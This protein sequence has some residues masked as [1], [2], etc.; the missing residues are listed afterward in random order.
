MG[1]ISKPLKV[2]T[3]MIHDPNM[4]SRWWQLTFRKK[5][6]PYLGEDDAIWLISFRLVQ[7]STLVS[8]EFIFFYLSKWSFVSGGESFGYLRKFVRFPSGKACY[9]N[10]L[11]CNQRSL[12]IFGLHRS[13]MELACLE[14]VW[15]V[16][17]PLSFQ[18][19]IS[20]VS[21]ALKT[22]FPP[23]LGEKKKPTKTTGFFP[24][25]LV[26][27]TGCTLRTS[28][29]PF[30]E[31]LAM[32]LFST[33]G[34]RSALPFPIQAQAWPCALAGFDVIA[35]APTGLLGWGFFCVFFFGGEIFVGWELFL[36]V[37]HYSLG[38][39]GGS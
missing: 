15:I 25:P 35:V 9:R 17:F 37:I 20:T 2:E 34:E 38:G 21:L 26:V 10:D 22:S 11:W 19:A 27:A 6:H 5:H 8:W 4:V 24:Q 39:I 18:T 28:F 12:F 36:R 30:V 1:E 3:P 23:Q 13:D 14:F 32:E 29:P 16:F 7:P 33:E 31:E